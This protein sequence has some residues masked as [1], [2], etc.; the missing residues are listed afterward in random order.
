MVLG[1]CHHRH[2]ISCRDLYHS[3]QICI[4]Q[5][6]LVVVRKKGMCAAELEIS[7]VIGAFGEGGPQGPNDGVIIFIM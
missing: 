7:I 3:Y 5:G 1:M 4:F 6:Y 2:A